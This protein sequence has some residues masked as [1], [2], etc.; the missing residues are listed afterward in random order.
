MA[1]IFQMRWCMI[2]RRG[3]TGLVV[4]VLVTALTAAQAAELDPIRRAVRQDLTARINRDRASARLRPVVLDAEFSRFADAHCARQL[5]E[6]TV[7]HFTLDG[8]PPYTRYSHAGSN[9][10]IAENA[11]AWSASYRFS[12]TSILDLTR[13]SHEAMMAERPPDDSHR[14]AILDPWATHVAI[15]IAWKDKEFRFVEV[16]FRRHIDWTS[17][18]DRN[19]RAGER[20]RASGRPTNGWSIAGV[21]VHH[22]PLPG[23][24]TR[25]RVNRIESYSLPGSS[26]EYRPL[27]P[28]M[29]GAERETLSRWASRNENGALRIRR[30]GSFSFDAP[31]HDG[32]GIYTLVVWLSGS[33]S[34]PPVAASHISTIVPPPPA[35]GS[36]PGGR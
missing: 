23:P 2:V 8:L 30:D 29:P 28:R 25:E 27:V 20:I 24:L 12:S 19:A 18:P 35:D 1:R 9:D 11:V 5:A 6:G 16:F 21:S 10:G 36:A 4:A 3:V 32:P 34:S 31:L 33:A 14:R 15:G 26:R 7:G 17:V 22:E 13:R